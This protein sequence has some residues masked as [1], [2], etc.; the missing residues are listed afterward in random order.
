MENNLKKEF[1]VYIKYLTTSIC[2]EICLEDMKQEVTELHNLLQKHENMIEKQEEQLKKNKKQ[3]RI[4]YLIMG[5]SIVNTF[6]GAA[7]LFF[8]L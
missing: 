6:V 7:I 3:I 5:L 1:E 2:K 8:V 4:M